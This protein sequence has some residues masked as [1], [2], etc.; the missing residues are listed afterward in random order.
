MYSQ[1]VRII[2][3]VTGRIFVGPQMN[4]NEE[5]IQ[6]S[7]TFTRDAFAGAT[8]LKTWSWWLRPFCRFFI[9]EFIRIR[10]HNEVARKFIDPIVRKRSREE[11]LEGYTKPDDSIEW[12]RDSL[13]ANAKNDLAYQANFQLVIGAASIHTTT[14]MITNTI[15]DLL[16]R[17]E[18]IEILREEAKAAL[19]EHG[20]AYVADSL[21]K[22]K[23]MDSFVKESQ[24]F[25]AIP[26]KYYFLSGHLYEP[27]S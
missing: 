8:E 24:R 1:M 18:Y 9:P 22:M 16:A 26:S 17:P 4:R 11:K 23:K 27:T 15:Y 14:Q 19:S 7:T 12:V 21:N 10:K 20:G 6:T 13:S 5:W 2:C 3:R 25:N